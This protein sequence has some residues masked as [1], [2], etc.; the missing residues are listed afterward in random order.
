MA[1]GHREVDA[2]DGPHRRPRQLV[3]DDQTLKPQSRRRGGLGGSRRHRPSAHGPGGGPPQA[4]VR[5]LLDCVAQESQAEDDGGQRQARGQDPPLPGVGEE[6]AAG[7]G[8]VEHRAPANPAGVAEA[9]ERKRRLEHHGDVGD[10]DE[11]HGGKGRDPRE[12]VPGDGPPAGAAHG[13][14]GEDVI[15]LAQLQHLG[16]QDPGWPGPQHRGQDADGGAQAPT[17]EGGQHDHEHQEREAQHQVDDAHQDGLGRPPVEAGHHRHPQPHHQGDGRRAQGD[18]Q[19]EPG[20]EQQLGQQVL[21][22]VVG[23][24]RVVARGAREG[25][26]R[27]LGR[28]VRR[29]HRGEDGD[30]HAAAQQEGAQHPHDP[31]CALGLPA[32]ARRRRRRS[33]RRRIGRAGGLDVGE[34]HARRGRG[35]RTRGSSSG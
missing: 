29:E 25:G 30:K 28:R 8:E 14:G 16:A 13:A 15:D 2:V 27:R 18:H 5:P 17:E 1:P 3:L 32:G 24:E 10:P 35:R 26:A 6:G 19:R 20:P 4:G 21:A 12:D 31:T 7:V 33:Q 34:G 11:L 9:E 22:H 23:A